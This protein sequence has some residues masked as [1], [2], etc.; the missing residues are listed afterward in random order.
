MNV[1]LKGIELKELKTFPDERGFFRE[2]LRFNDPIFEGLE[3]QQLSHSLTKKDVIKAWH[4][5][6][7]QNDFWYLA[8]GKIKV[9]LADMREDSDTYLK[10]NEL[11]LDANENPICLKISPGIAHGYKVLSEEAHM[12]YLMDKTYNPDD[13]NRIEADDPRIGFKW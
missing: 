11:I 10:S 1:K 6:R 12:I 8:S 4:F 5:H 3:F 9:G 13:E 2:I 7:L